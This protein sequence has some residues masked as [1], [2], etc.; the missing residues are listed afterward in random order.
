MNK[1]YPQMFTPIKIGN[2]TLKNRVFKSAAEDSCVP[3]GYVNDYLCKFYAEEAHGGAGLIIGGMYVITPREKP[4]NERHP[5]LERDDRIPGFGRLAAAIKDNGAVPCC[6]IGHFG[7]HGT[8]VTPDWWRCVS[9]KALEIPGHEEWY[10]IFKAAY[11]QG[12]RKNWPIKE[13]SKEE[14]HELVGF[15]GDGARRAKTADFPIVEVHAAHRHGLGCFLS[16]LTNMRSDEYGGSVA[17]RARI[18]YEI[19]DDIQKKC[20]KN[21]PIIVRL[22]GVDGAG[23][24]HSPE[25]AQNGQQIDQTIEIAKHLEK[26]G[27]AALNISVQD[28]N[29]PMQHKSYGV[30]VK[31]ADQVRQA[32]NIPVMVAG[33]IQTPEYAESVLETGKADMVGGA[34]SFYADPNWVRKAQWGDRDD[35]RPCIRC[36]QC[37]V[38]NWTGPLHC[39]L[40]P[41]VGKPQLKDELQPTDVKRRVAVVGGGPAGIEA[42]TVAASRGHDVTIF[43]K[44]RLGGMLYAASA[45]DFKADIRRFLR[46]QLKQVKKFNIHVK[47]QLADSKSL[48]NYDAVIVATGSEPASLPVKG[49]DGQNVY[50]AIDLLNQSVGQDSPRDVGKKMVIIGGGSVGVETAIWYAENGHDVT[51][52]EIQ[53]QILKDEDLVTGP[54]DM[55]MIKQNH[56]QVMAQTK[57]LAIDPK[58]VS[59]QADGQTKQLAA[60]AV[61][62]A[63]GTKAVND[64]ALQLQKDLAVP[65]FTAGDCN[66]PRKIYQAVHEGFEAATQIWDG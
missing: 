43:E 35:I 66:Q 8:T 6:Q 37:V 54:M 19:V 15:Y 26:Q 50:S 40:N 56:V 45:P 44:N 65:V 16:P 49:A 28:T 57:L 47:Y 51:V 53:D 38:N 13:Y 58:G 46:Y 30:A 9:K 1:N 24:M 7:S 32:V 60:D 23:V 10:D 25:A 4:G 3:D 18:L 62:I 20:G 29:V 21:Y 64:L 31:Y 27:V 42:A 41:T 48:A 55:M 39:A 52:V 14:I 22:N 33:S 2:V 59:V 34:R 5:M 36:M 17:N 61:V 11:W 12:Q 63:T